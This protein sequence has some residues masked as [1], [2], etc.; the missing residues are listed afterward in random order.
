MKI[1]KIIGTVFGNSDHLLI[2]FGASSLV[3]AILLS[4]FLYFLNNKTNTFIHHYCTIG[5]G[6]FYGFWLASFTD[7]NNHKN[8]VI[9]F[10]KIIPFV[11]L[12]G[13]SLGFFVNIVFDLQ[14]QGFPSGSLAYLI[15]FTIILFC[16]IFYY[17]TTFELIFRIF[18]R[19]FI[20]LKHI[21]LNSDS[22]STHGFRNLIENLTVVLVT[23]GGLM[24]AFV[25]IGNSIKEIAF[26]FSSKM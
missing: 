11:F 17:I 20:K 12:T 6:I 2:K 3:I 4:L 24:G 8:Y 9:H 18:K 14:V 15:I 16:C 5:A 23:I 26:I 25:A 1:K 7:E 10:L 22:S 19:V 13:Y 21:L